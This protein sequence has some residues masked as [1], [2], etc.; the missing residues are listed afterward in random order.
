[1]MPKRRA[2]L[3][4][5]SSLPASIHG[6]TVTVGVAPTQVDAPGIDRPWGEDG[7]GSIVSSHTQTA[8]VIPGGGRFWVERGEHVVV[9]AGPDD[10]PAPW[11]YGTVGAFVLAQQGRFALHANVVEVNGRGIV[12]AGR[13]R[14]GKST[15]SMALASAG[16]RL[17]TDDVATLDVEGAGVI[18]PPAGRPVHIHPQTAERLGISLSDGVP[19]EGDPTKLALPNP[20]GAP[21]KIASIILL[22]A[23][24]DGSALMLDDVE[25]ARSAMVLHRHAYRRGVLAPLWSADT[26]LWASSVAQRVPVRQLVRPADGWTVDA[27]RAAL[28]A[29][30]ADA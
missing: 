25:P 14:A 29:A 9:E 4:H 28:E 15:T 5:R 18:H 2:A 22:A 11:L 17:V 16:H 19:V 27:V 7:S 8:C 1:M 20:A 26:F 12:I 10:E 13:R 3:L 6:A 24:P 23:D 21:V 30:A